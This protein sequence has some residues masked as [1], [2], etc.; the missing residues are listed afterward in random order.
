[1]L[2]DENRLCALV[3]YLAQLHDDAILWPLGRKKFALNKSPQYEFPLRPQQIVTMQ[4]ETTAAVPVPEPITAWEPFVP[5]D[6]LPALHAYD[7]NLIGH[8]PFGS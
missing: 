6:K 8:P 3:H 1:V 4:F 2:T 7:P 5:K